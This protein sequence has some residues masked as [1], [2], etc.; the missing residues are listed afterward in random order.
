MTTYFCF[1]TWSPTFKPPDDRDLA[2]GPVL[3]LRV[4]DVGL[5]RGRGE[6]HG[7]VTGGLPPRN[8][9]CASKGL[10]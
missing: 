3:L 1:M 9:G 8:Q 6:G 2:G 5:L 7:A 10:A 4:V